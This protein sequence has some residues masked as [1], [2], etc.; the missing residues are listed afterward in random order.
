MRATQMFTKNESLSDNIDQEIQEKLKNL[1]KKTQ[2]EVVKQSL[3]AFEK[4][5][6]TKRPDH[7]SGGDSK[8]D[9]R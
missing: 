1:D 6:N 9:R 5:Y 3:E 7:H 4:A 8:A 2:N